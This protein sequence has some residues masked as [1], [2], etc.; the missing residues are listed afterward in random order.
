MYD[1][2]V[3]RKHQN[4]EV[5]S[6]PNRKGAL[7]AESIRLHIKK[8]RGSLKGKD[9]LKALMDDRTRERALNCERRLK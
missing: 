6:I 1:F 9:V 5:G 8:L 3:R 7:H 4:G 2:D